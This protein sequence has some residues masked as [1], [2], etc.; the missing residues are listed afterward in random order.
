MESKQS[1]KEDQEMI[2]FLMTALQLI[3][4]EPGHQGEI[5][6]PKCS[7]ILT[8]NRSKFNGHVWGICRTNGCLRWMQ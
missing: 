6:C 7:G 1:K 8:W 4:K 2:K 5:T 3:K